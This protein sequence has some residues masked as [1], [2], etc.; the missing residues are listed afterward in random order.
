MRALAHVPLKSF[1]GIIVGLL[2]VMLQ[3][4]G[5]DIHADV[6]TLTANLL[7]FAQSA[8]YLIGFGLTLWGHLQLAGQHVALRQV[9]YNAGVPAADINAPKQALKAAADAAAS[10]SA[11][12]P[13]SLTG[14]GQSTD[15]IDK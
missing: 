12:P 2:A 15:L 14:P 5:V 9:A 6:P 1:V 8:A 11:S 7:Q 13:Q 3:F 4:V 10:P